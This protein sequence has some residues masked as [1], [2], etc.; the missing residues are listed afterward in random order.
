MH[1]KSFWVNRVQFEGI[2][3]PVEQVELDLTGT[4]QITKKSEKYAA[5]LREKFGNQDDVVA[6]IYAKEEARR[7]QNEERAQKLLLEREKKD[8]SELTFAPKT[9]SSTMATDGEPTH[10]ERH[11]D[12]YSRVA[13]GSLALKVMRAT[14]EL[15]FEKS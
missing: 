10:G 9:L 11:L 15:E 1:F 7:K 6:A 2:K 12:L 8:E 4:P 13:Q 5:K 14:E 3:K